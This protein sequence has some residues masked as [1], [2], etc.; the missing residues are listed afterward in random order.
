MAVACPGLAQAAGTNS[1]QSASFYQAK[2]TTAGFFFSRLL[3]RIY[4]LE[5]CIRAGSNTL[6]QLDEAQF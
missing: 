1:A 3:P 6:Y 4:S 5:A 2:Q